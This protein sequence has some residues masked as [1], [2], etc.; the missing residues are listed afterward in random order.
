[1]ILFASGMAAPSSP[2]I[3]F[4]EISRSSHRTRA[5]SSFYAPLP[6]LAVLSITIEMPCTSH[7]SLGTKTLWLWTDSSSNTPTLYVWSTS[8]KHCV[9]YQFMLPVAPSCEQKLDL[10]LVPSTASEMLKKLACWMRV[11]RT[12][13][14]RKSKLSL[15]YMCFIKPEI[16]INSRCIR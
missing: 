8:Q 5:F 16:H 11:T 6:D 10:C 9:N 7:S 12:R 14:L 15:K 13:T 3:F 2:F 4:E 1:M